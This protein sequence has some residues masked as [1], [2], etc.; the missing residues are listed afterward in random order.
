[1]VQVKDKP[2]AESGHEGLMLLQRGSRGCCCKASSGLC[3]RLCSHGAGFLHFLQRKLLNSLYLMFKWTTGTETPAPSFPRSKE[4]QEQQARA[5]C[6]LQAPGQ[7]QEGSASPRQQPLCPKQGCPG[8]Q[9]RAG[10]PGGPPLHTP[11]SAAGNRTQHPA[12]RAAPPQP[13]SQQGTAPGPTGPAGTGNP[14]NSRSN[15]QPKQPDYSL[16]RVLRKQQYGVCPHGQPGLQHNAASWGHTTPLQLRD[17]QGRGF[18]TGQS[19]EWPAGSGPWMLV[20]TL[21]GTLIQPGPAV[22]AGIQQQEPHA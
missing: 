14:G 6:P 7:G 3:Q 11:H 20:S 13:R 4:Q 10:R 2:A 16:P 12:P 17:T 5:V 15:Q 8:T 18:G 1:M 21:H 22:R 9:P 19:W